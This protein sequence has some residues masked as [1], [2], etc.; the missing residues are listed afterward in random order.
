LLRLTPAER[1]LL[2]QAR[3]AVLGTITSNGRPRLVP[4]TYAAAEA[5]DELIVYFALD[6]KP[7]S[8]ADPHD[9]ARVR[10]IREHPQVSVLIDEW[11]ED[12]TRLAWLRLDGRAALLEADGNESAEHA[13]AARLLR[14]RYPQYADHRLDERPIIR[15]TIERAVSWAAQR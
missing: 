2:D 11:Q 9:L 12:W 3:R 13:L 7:K 15:I 5:N 6:D 4:I 10:D 8:V 1:D 14:E